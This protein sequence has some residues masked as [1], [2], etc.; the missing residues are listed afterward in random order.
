[1]IVKMKMG[2]KAINIV[3]APSKPDGA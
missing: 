2:K 3:K 1:M